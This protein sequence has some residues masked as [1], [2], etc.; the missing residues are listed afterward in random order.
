MCPPGGAP[1][2]CCDVPAPGLAHRARSAHRDAGRLSPSRLRRRRRV[3]RCRGGGPPREGGRASPRTPA[4]V[5]EVLESE[6]RLTSPKTSFAARK[7]TNVGT[8]SVQGTAARR[9]RLFLGKWGDAGE[10]LG[11]RAP[12]GVE[13]PGELVVV[14]KAR[15]ENP[16]LR[17][18]LPRSSGRRNGHLGEMWESGPRGDVEVFA[19]RIARASSASIL[20]RLAHVRVG[21]SPADGRPLGA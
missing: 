19:P 4:R 12:S 15:V 16:L 11:T 1:A 9:L 17:T 18:F 7:S 5:T 20:S 14:G 13:R 3:T 10:Q 21:G 6:E 2:A 8:P